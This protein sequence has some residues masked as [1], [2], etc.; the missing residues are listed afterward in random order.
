MSSYQDRIRATTNLDELCAEL[1][2]IEAE[3]AAANTGALTDSNIGEHIDCADLPTFGGEWPKDTL[4][5]WSWD[6][7]RILYADGSVWTVEPRPTN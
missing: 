2:R 5:I 3:I 7:T 1:N 4:G 6:E